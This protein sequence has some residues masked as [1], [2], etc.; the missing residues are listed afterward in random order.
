MCNCS[1]CAWRALAGLES[2][3]SASVHRG[4]PED[5]ETTDGTENTMAKR[6][7]PVAE[8][9]EAPKETPKVEVTKEAPKVEM[10]KEEVFEV[11]N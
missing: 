2:T 7:A 1:A 3:L 8:K 9:T 10:P 6:P 5:I 4:A 11:M